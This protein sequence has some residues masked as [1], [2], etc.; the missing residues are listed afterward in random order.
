M[1]RPAVQDVDVLMAEYRPVA[2]RV[3]RLAAELATA[4]AERNAVV[5]ALAEAGLTQR[6]ICDLTGLTVAQVRTACW[7]DWNA[8]RPH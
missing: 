1:T 6:A 4:T 8:N 5:A 7:A 3:G 2:E